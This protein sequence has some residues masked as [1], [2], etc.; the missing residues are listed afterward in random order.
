MKKVIEFDEKC[1]ACD[2]TGLYCG[3]GERDGAA[4]VC[5]NC[6][7]TGR[8][9][10][11]HEYEEFSARVDR[12]EIKRV[13]QTNPGI[14]MGVGAGCQLKDFGGLSLKEWQDGKPF[15]PGTENRNYTCPC[16]WYQSAD[17]RLKPEWKECL[18][19]GGPFYDCPKFSNKAQCWKRWDEENAPKT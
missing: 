9:K 1:Q 10:F 2:G 12:P 16:W 7:G 5:H 15:G 3:M 6:K 14:T 4:V 11:R 13:Y 18:P 8:Y 19:L 17:Y